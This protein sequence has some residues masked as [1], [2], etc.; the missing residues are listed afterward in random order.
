M[1][2]VVTWIAPRGLV[3]V[4]LLLHA[5]NALQVP[6]Y[7]NGAVIIVVLVSSALIGVARLKLAKSEANA[8]T[9]TSI[10]AQETET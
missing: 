1:A 6:G 4:L 5:Q 2:D 9:D 3:T 10:K 7:L 8:D